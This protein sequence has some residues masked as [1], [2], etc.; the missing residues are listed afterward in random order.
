MQNNEG[1]HMSNDYCD[2]LS[3]LANNIDPRGQKYTTTTRNTAA[4]K[5]KSLM[6]EILSE[7]RTLKTK[8]AL[9][10]GAEKQAIVTEL[11]SHYSETGEKTST[12]AKTRLTENII[13]NSDVQ[14]YINDMSIDEFSSLRMELQSTFGGP[15]A[16]LLEIQFKNAKTESLTKELEEL[17]KYTDAVKQEL[18]DMKARGILSDADLRM[19]RGLEN[20][21]T[22]DDSLIKA[23][24][25]KQ[26]YANL[27]SSVGET[28]TQEIFATKIAKNID[29]ITDITKN[30]TMTEKYV[31]KTVPTEKE[32]QLM[33]DFLSGATTPNATT[34]EE[35]TA[36]LE[37]VSK[38]GWDAFRGALSGTD[39]LT[40]SER[41]GVMGKV[42]S[43]LWDKA[44]STGKAVITVAG[45]ALT[46][47]VG[48]PQGLLWFATSTPTN[49]AEMTGLYEQFKT[50]DD[51]TDNIIS[52][53]LNT[54][55]MENINNF[56]KSWSA[57]SIL[58]KPPYSLLLAIPWY[59]E[60]LRGIWET[61]IKEN[62]NAI[63]DN[64][65]RIF[66]DLESM[67]L[68]HKCSSQLGYCTSTEEERTE[69]YKKNMTALMGRDADFV[70]S[71]L[72]R[73]YKEL[74]KMSG[75]YG[76]GG[77]LT[78]DQAIILYMRATGQID[79]ATTEKLTGLDTTEIKEY[80]GIDATTIKGAILAWGEE[81][82]GISTTE[83]T[84]ETTPKTTQ[85]WTAEELGKSGL[86]CGRGAC[87]EEYI[88]NM[89]KNGFGIYQKK[90]GT[91]VWSRLEEAEDDWT[92][93]S[94]AT[95]EISTRSKSK[96]GSS[97]TS[98]YINTIREN[99]KSGGEVSDEEKQTVANNAIASNKNYIESM[100]EVGVKPTEAN[101]LN[102]IA[103]REAIPEYVKKNVKDMSK[104]EVLEMVAIN[105][106]QT[107]KG[108]MEAIE[109]T[110]GD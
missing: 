30:P 106:E 95:G 55:T 2:G 9:A 105:K 10:T 72:S 38:N 102:Q 54:K 35:I 25:A 47:L 44:S 31:F 52:K 80:T 33:K 75:I 66:S 23:G 37:K 20:L 108:L 89:K 11:A 46:A 93:I 101:K 57:E 74:P 58:G 65:N 99:M 8:E 12:L 28:I 107:G 67:G 100:N 70:R 45:I 76:K 43:S 7:T 85:M 91:I 26:T 84:S 109:C 79:D 96:G 18:S 21:K 22:F 87:T 32:K 63:S 16:R 13:A 34:Y 5:G 3:T 81:N 59:G 68:V 86:S 53:L 64:F 56:L 24:T 83:K 60:Y 39:E 29:E 88:T 97:S 104:E 110:G 71:E 41:M 92:E 15:Q 40:S 51:K 36:L 48:I 103:F 77:E 78:R 82:I 90:D 17:G 49:I 27:K 62:S 42:K 61:P 1:M 98:S 6:D 73:M 94:A 4:E 14:A 50:G 19:L 69:F